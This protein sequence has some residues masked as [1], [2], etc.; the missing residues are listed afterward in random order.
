[1]RR[2]LLLTLAVIALVA[3]RRSDSLLNPQFWA[4]DGAIF[5]AEAERYG[6]WGLLFHPYEGY[7]HLI[8][9]VIAAIAL[10]AGVPLLHLPAFYAWSALAITG[11]MA[12]WLQ[13]PRI[14]L[15]GGWIATLALA[16]I[17]HNGE[18]FL[19]LCNLQWITAL[20]LFALA[21]AADPTSPVSRV[22]DLLLLIF[23]GLTGPF[24]ILALPLFAWRAWCRR[25]CWSGALLACAFACAAAH[26]PAL[27]ARSVPPDLPAWAPFHHAA[28]LGRRVVAS[29]FLGHLPFGELPSIALALVVPPLLAW[30][31]WSRRAV[32]PGGIALLIAALLVLAA[33]GY[34]GRPD[35]W[36]L[37]EFVNGDRYFFIPK[38]ILIW[39]LGAFALT[40]PPRF[41]R[42]FFLLLLL[43]LAVN[44]PRF[45]IPP[46]PDQNWRASCL[47][48]ARGEPVW[49]PILPEGTGV[50]HP[51]RRHH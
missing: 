45:F 5:F 25:S 35:T 39:L 6:G 23:T 37:S 7:L 50:F 41:R 44:A 51:G 46:S 19:T 40:S 20:G 21:L 33:T 28:I 2:R 30:L 12:W 29:L 10:G 13:S 42:A 49:L 38:I 26:L 36:T 34:K 16:L 48:I 31:L 17:P 11:C 4:E 32:L 9:R 1:M 24:V 3:L 43:P 22:G 8:P 15:P 27:L 14:A 47:L 18:I